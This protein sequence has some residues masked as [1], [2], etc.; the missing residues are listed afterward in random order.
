MSCS[1]K[2]RGCSRYVK[3]GG[4]VDC[5]GYAPPCSSSRGVEWEGR[6]DAVSAGGGHGLLGNRAHG[7]VCKMSYAKC[8]SSV[9]C[10]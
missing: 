3:G 4:S 1:T 5:V 8:R 2:T 10:V 7:G 9:G 6:G